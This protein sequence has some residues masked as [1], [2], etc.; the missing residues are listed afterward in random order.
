VLT[1]GAGRS[2][3]RGLVAPTTSTGRRL[4][5]PQDKTYAATKASAIRRGS[6][7]SSADAGAA[8]YGDNDEDDASFVDLT[9]E[10]DLT[11]REGG[12][13]H[14]TPRNRTGTFQHDD[15]DIDFEDDRYLGDDTTTSQ[16]D[17]SPPKTMQFHVPQS[18]L[19]QTPAREASRR[20]VDDLLMTAGADATDE[21][22]GGSSVLGADEG[23]ELT[24]RYGRLVLDDDDDD[25]DFLTEEEAS[26]SLVK[27]AQGMDDT[28]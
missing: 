20:I 11:A 3:Q 5:S 17:M 14:A 10:G 25:D 28:F 12:S 22:E 24:G 4:F 2:H 8:G 13:V 19:L 6:I 26:P 18:R 1:P 7:F 23:R 21:I 15:D 9:A 27:R 16:F